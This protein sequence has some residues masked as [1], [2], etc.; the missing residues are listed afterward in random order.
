MP[1][2]GG[3]ANRLRRLYAVLGNEGPEVTTF[4][5]GLL[6]SFLMSRKITTLS[7][8]LN[9]F[10]LNTSQCQDF[11]LFVLESLR[12][13]YSNRPK[14]LGIVVG[15]SAAFSDVDPP[16]S[17]SRREVDT[18]SD[19]MSNIT[20]TSP[21][22]GPSSWAD[23]VDLA[24]KE[25]ESELRSYSSVASQ[26]ERKR[27]KVETVVVDKY[28]ATARLRKLQGDFSI[29]SIELA[30]R[31]IEEPYAGYREKTRL[32]LRGMISM[33]LKKIPFFSKETR[34]I[35]RT[36]MYNAIQKLRFSYKV[37]IYSGAE[38]DFERPES[39]PDLGPSA[40]VVVRLCRDVPT[41]LNHKVYFD[42][43]Y[44]SLSLID[45]LKKKRHSVPRYG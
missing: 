28:Q 36:H 39:E 42:N 14:L 27:A 43:Y 8:A 17:P 32:R 45:Y 22:P 16:I 34:T 26:P 9:G 20:V 13:E 4:V 25:E 24:E 19:R 11:Y 7:F 29:M 18:M 31:T 6:Q 40:N 23:Q 21:V 38:N 10:S 44:T 35:C 12:N 15:F 3:I 2:V 41:G 5:E 1:S 30:M 37:E 33:Y